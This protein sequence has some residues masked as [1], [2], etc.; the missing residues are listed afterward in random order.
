MVRFDQPCNGLQLSE[1]GKV[2]SKCLG[3]TYSLSTFLLFSKF[4]EASF[5]SVVV[6]VSAVKYLKLLLLPEAPHS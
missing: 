6:G 4:K 5:S 3:F 2:K 1:H